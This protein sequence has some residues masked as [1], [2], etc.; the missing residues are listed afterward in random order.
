[1]SDPEHAW[2]V[3]VW[4]YAELGE[5]PVWDDR[6]G[7]LIWVDINSGRLHRYRPGEGDE[8]LVELG[9]SIGAAALRKEGGYVLAAGDGFRILDESG[10][11]VEGPI[12]P[13]GMSDS[14]RFNDG[15]CD[16][17][18]R[19]WAGT[20]S[21]RGERGAAALYALEP[22]GEVNLVLE[23]VT[24]SNGIAW[25]P[26]AGTMYYVD[27]GREDGAIISFAFDPDSAK[28][29]PPSKFIA[30]P[31]AGGVPD[32]L[33]VDRE[34]CLWVAY[35]GGGC[36]RRYAPDGSLLE[37]LDLPVAYPTCPGFGGRELDTIYVTSAWEGMPSRDRLAQPLSGCLFSLEAGTPGLP[38]A[39]FG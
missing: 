9:V 19:F 31:P 25:S 13:S 10:S 35:W 37:V 24:E 27:S 11:M 29:G 39:R 22:G 17:A 32:G 16:P 8:V 34:G 36:L 28:L 30:D 3:V 38:S 12:R 2:E 33:T 7:C 1:M 20:T 4:A 5:R 6:S 21:L 26:D 18:G 15:A 14:T 23:G